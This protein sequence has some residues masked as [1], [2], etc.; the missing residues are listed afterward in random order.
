M[1]CVADS[2]LYRAFAREVSVAYGYADNV[3]TRCSAEGD[4]GVLRRFVPVSSSPRSARPISYTTPVVKLAHGSTSYIQ[5]FNFGIR[6]FCEERC[7]A[8]A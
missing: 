7:M 6:N 1:L 2:T 4:L 3:T 5:S 8:I